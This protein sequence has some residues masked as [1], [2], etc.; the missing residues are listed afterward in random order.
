MM[1][2]AKRKNLA[3]AERPAKWDLRL[4]VADQS[5]QSMRAFQNLKDACKEHMSG[6]YHITVIDVLT[7]PEA[8]RH[9]QIVA[10]PT[11]IRRN[12]KPVRTGIGDLTNTGRL[13]DLL[14]QN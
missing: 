13:L 8:A 9:D 3:K 11:L 10:L 14:N 6:R 2:A 1:S 4:Y 7:H 12:P 5:P